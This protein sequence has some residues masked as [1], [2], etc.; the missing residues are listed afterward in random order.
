MSRPLGDNRAWFD[1]RFPWVLR[2]VCPLRQRLLALSILLSAPWTS[3]SIRLPWRAFPYL[4][5]PHSIR[6]SIV[7]EGR[8]SYQSY[9]I[10]SPECRIE[11]R[12]NLTATDSVAIRQFERPLA[13]GHPENKRGTRSS[14]RS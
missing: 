2:L 1:S 3:L 6:A 11:V 5:R 10:A 12:K 13:A 4:W 7:L 8:R 9:C 14:S